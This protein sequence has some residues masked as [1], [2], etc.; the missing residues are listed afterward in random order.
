M[1]FCCFFIDLERQSILPTYPKW[2]QNHVV[3]GKNFD[4]WVGLILKVWKKMFLRGQEAERHRRIKMWGCLIL[5][6]EK[7]V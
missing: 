6:N 4:W 2:D 3:R 7:E 1:F 5:I